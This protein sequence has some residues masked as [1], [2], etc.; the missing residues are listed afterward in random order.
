MVCVLSINRSNSSHSASS[1]SAASGPALTNLYVSGSPSAVRLSA[2][3]LFC[4][5]LSVLFT[6]TA[7]GAVLFATPSPTT[8]AARPRCLDLLFAVAMAPS[9]VACCAPPLV[10]C[11]VT[12]SVGSGLFLPLAICTGLVGAVAGVGGAMG[13]FGA[14]ACGAGPRCSKPGGTASSSSTLCC[15]GCCGCNTLCSPAP[16]TSMRIGGTG[17]GGRSG[18][19][20]GNVGCCAAAIG[21]FVLAPSPPVALASY[22]DAMFRNA[23]SRVSVHCSNGCRSAANR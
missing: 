7:R 9:A 15:T 3:V 19:G 23:P 12:R 22:I 6:P 10:P 21:A 13:T 16:S 4:S 11:L 18:G 8:F 5:G 14:S 17:P 20:D 2:P 1:H